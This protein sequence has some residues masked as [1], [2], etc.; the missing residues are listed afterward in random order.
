MGPM[1]TRGPGRS[2]VSLSVCLLL[3]PPAEAAVRGLWR[4]LEAA[5]VPTLLTHT[6]GR[7]VPHLTLASVHHDGA[8]AVV[9]ALSPLPVADRVEVSLD[10]LGMFPRSR[11]WLAVPADR[12]L[13][14]RQARVVEAVRSA[15][16]QVHAHY[17]P[18]AWLPHLTM[19]P[20]MRV[21][22]VATLARLVFEV[23]PLRTSLERAAVVET[24][25]GRVHPLPHLV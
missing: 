9:S 6:H 3:D 16:G 25:T 7:H 1:E 19:G 20:R 5:G 14:M 17:L 11:S 21:E 13:L 8:E 24:G 23:L 10:A 2:T 22:Q 12:D 4:R 18:G 15:G